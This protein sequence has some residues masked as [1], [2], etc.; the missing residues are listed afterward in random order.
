MAQ[1]SA[2]ASV[3]SAKSARFVWVQVDV[4]TVDAELI[5]LVGHELCHALEVI[6]EPT[7]RDNG[8]MIFLYKRIGAHGAGSTIDTTAAITAGRR[9]R[10][11]LRD[12]ERRAR[13]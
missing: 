13:E 11:E 8:A 7:V 10:K 5:S 4:R 12:S 9:I 6:E 3:T 2:H 1:A